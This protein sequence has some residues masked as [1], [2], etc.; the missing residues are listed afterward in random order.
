MAI[1][2]DAEHD[3]QVQV[4]DED[5]ST[6]LR[7]KKYMPAGDAGG[8]VDEHGFPA[9]RMVA[10]NG[11]IYRIPLTEAADAIDKED[12]R[13][14]T[15]ADA[16][17]SDHPVAGRAM[18]ASIGAL[19]AG[20]LGFTG[21][22][23]DAATGDNWSQATAQ[24]YPGTRFGVE[25]PASISLAAAGAI[26]AIRGVGSAAE[27]ARAAT[28]A[29]LA[30]EA[31]LVGE[32]ANPAGEV[33][34]QA[35][36]AGSAATTKSALRSG[37]G[38]LKEGA[39]FTPTG[40]ISAAT[41]RSQEW[42][43]GKLGSAMLQAS[44]PS[45]VGQELA[46]VGKPLGLMTSMLASIGS[47]AGMALGAAPE[48]ALYA[49]SQAVN[50]KMLGD[51][52]EWGALLTTAFAENGAFAFGPAFALGALKGAAGAGARAF[53]LK[54]SSYLTNLVDSG[55]IGKAVLDEEAQALMK[56]TGGR[57]KPATLQRI[58]ERVPEL[59]EAL[60]NEKR[61]IPTDFTDKAGIFHKAGSVFVDSNG[62]ALP[63]TEDLMSRLKA[64]EE[65]HGNAIGVKRSYLS[66]AQNAAVS[67]EATS[68][69][70]LPA[71]SLMVDGKAIG[72]KIGELQVKD[73]PSGITAQQKEAFLASP[74]QRMMSAEKAHFESMGA[75]SEDAVR[76][77]IARLDAAYLGKD[78]AM[79]DGKF[80]ARQVNRILRNA[81]L[82]NAAKILPA[83]Q[84][85][86]WKDSNEIFHSVKSLNAAI[87]GAAGEDAPLHGVFAL[88]QK[89]FHRAGWI[90]TMRA[91]FAMRSAIE[92][93]L[94]GRGPLPGVAGLAMIPPAMIAGIGGQ[95]ALGG[96]LPKLMPTTERI[97]NIAHNLTAFKQWGKAI[98]SLDGFTGD[99][100]AQWVRN[101]GKVIQ[102]TRLIGENVIRELGE[103]NDPNVAV[104]K[105]Q[106]RFASVT[107][108]HEI[109][110]RYAQQATA[111][112][113]PFAPNAAL[114]AGAAI[115]RHALIANHIL[116]T[117]N[118]SRPKAAFQPALSAKMPFS[119]DALSKAGQQLAAVFR[120]KD[121]L[122]HILAG[123]ASDAVV[124]TF[125]LAHP[126]YFLAAAKTLHLAIAGMLNRLSTWQLAALQ[127]MGV[128][129]G[130]TLNTAPAILPQP[131]QA[132][133]MASRQ[134]R[135][136]QQ[137]QGQ[138]PAVSRFQHLKP[139]G[140][141]FAHNP[142]GAALG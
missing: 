4:K 16:F 46:Q 124:Q 101:P 118:E 17:E 96:L 85:S 28:A 13:L 107:S 26:G 81:E 7:S 120:P 89:A 54:V 5:V 33:A 100:I 70:G 112:I 84:V 135:Q 102:G 47:G 78:P 69:A 83:D 65:Y 8:V 68:P 37:W 115:S 38:A 10:P 24:Q 29:S 140:L 15:H 51:P 12:M 40:I 79:R 136:T 92:G 90:S 39:A 2:Y 122:P 76:K 75:M 44:M 66:A 133:S 110:A 104:S 132:P 63:P 61:L 3:Q 88:V 73:L 67:P 52:R 130:A 80:A 123:T 9:A 91:S 36:K 77:D 106:R 97:G 117:L 87:K 141:A 64:A 14:V 119:K 22:L 32:V 45:L 127:K 56:M 53:E 60:G 125:K 137:S 94:S 95:L 20:T 142:A 82:E 103:H 58:Y 6:L 121:V 18:A 93:L 114:S 11:E 71:S 105:L 126:E 31:G 41:S 35:I 59:Y 25:L 30:K 139:E 128:R 111:H 74:Y 99:K 34:A 50:E 108:S 49:V 113:A 109:M 131:P 23:L 1:L 138:S 72:Q 62:E 57:L 134:V 27:V 48:A 43:A 19:N 98:E 86:Q 55:E 21:P 129:D 116:Q 42:L